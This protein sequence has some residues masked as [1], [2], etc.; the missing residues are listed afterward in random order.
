MYLQ[1]G[2]QGG[3]QT[4]GVSSQLPACNT[5]GRSHSNPLC[6]RITAYNNSITN[7]LL[8]AAAAAAAVPALLLHG[9]G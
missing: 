3:G 5:R 1:A 9:G 6:L 8:S 7:A 4:A 2:T